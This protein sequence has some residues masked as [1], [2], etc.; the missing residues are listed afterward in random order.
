MM[1]ID[2]GSAEVDGRVAFDLPNRLCVSVVLEGFNRWTGMAEF[3][4]G[5][6]YGGSWLWNNPA[7]IRCTQRGMTVPEIEELIDQ[8]LKWTEEDI[9]EWNGGGKLTAQNK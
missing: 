8:A 1:K 5:L 2:W 6:W 4:V 9:L 3:E 7:G